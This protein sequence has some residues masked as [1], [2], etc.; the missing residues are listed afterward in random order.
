M[1]REE[2]EKRAAGINKDGFRM[3]DSMRH[4]G[5]VSR[6]R[7]SSK[8]PHKRLY[9]MLKSTALVVYRLKETKD[10]RGRVTKVELDEEPKQIVPL[11]PTTTI[12]TFGGG[13]GLYSTAPAVLGQLSPPASLPPP[14]HARARSELTDSSS[15]AGTG[16]WSVTSASLAPPSLPPP[17]SGGGN[18]RSIKSALPPGRGRKVP[19]AA[20]VSPPSLPPP[21]STGSSKGKGSPPKLPPPSSTPGKDAPDP[22]LSFK[23]SVIARL[24]LCS[25]VLLPPVMLQNFVCHAIESLCSLAR[26]VP[27]MRAYFVWWVRSSRLTPAR[28]HCY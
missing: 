16:T 21:S 13:G 28:T 5:Y 27:Y 20:V 2:R 7:K 11:T 23:V 14:G 4:S 9:I 15:S 10:F 17:S 6:Y 25:S 1:R 19:G 8:T 24:L 26:L 12:Q 3:P 18:S 22:T